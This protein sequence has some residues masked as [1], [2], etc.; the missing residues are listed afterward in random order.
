MGVVNLS[1]PLRTPRENG[2]FLHAGTPQKELFGYS[3]GMRVQEPYAY[4]ELRGVP[5]DAAADVWTRVRALLPWAALRLNFG[6][7]ASEGGDVGRGPRG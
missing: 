6:I 3:L 7:R 1:I 2:F 4:L 5:A